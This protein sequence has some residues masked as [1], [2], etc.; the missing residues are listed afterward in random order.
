MEEKPS[1]VE[2]K[3]YIEDQLNLADNLFWLEDGSQIDIL[4]AYSRDAADWA[5]RNGLNIGT[6]IYMMLNRTNNALADSGINT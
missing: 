6:E 5:Q 2:I 4:I 3:E 1:P